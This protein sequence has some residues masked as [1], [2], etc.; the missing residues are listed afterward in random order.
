MKFLHLD[1][2][3]DNF[4]KTGETFHWE[5]PNLEFCSSSKIGLSNIVIDFSTKP[6]NVEPLQ[7]STNLVERDLYNPDGIIATFSPSKKDLVHYSPV[8]AMWKVDS[9]RPRQ[10]LFTLHGAKAD[11][12]LFLS[13]VLAIE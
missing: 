3:M 7:V 8:L 13:I 1:T 6:G 11:S 2:K 12:V 5:L 10:V 4:T 9:I